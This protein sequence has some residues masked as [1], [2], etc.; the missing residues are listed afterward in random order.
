MIQKYM[1]KYLLHFLLTKK[2][3]LI[4]RQ[5]QKTLKD[6]SLL[7]SLFSI[8]SNKY[9]DT[10]INITIYKSTIKHKKVTKVTVFSPFSI[11]TLSSKQRALYNKIIIGL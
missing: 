8:K 9:N 4:E 1:I 5:Q 6:Y 10:S 7:K 11:V 3:I 2:E